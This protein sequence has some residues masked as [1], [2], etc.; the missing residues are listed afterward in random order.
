MTRP[1]PDIPRI[2]MEC[3]RN[4]TAPPYRSSLEPKRPD[5]IFDSQGPTIAVASEGAEVFV[6]SDLHLASGRG[7]DGRYDGC[8]NF[9]F[10]A[11][12]RRF[13]EYANARPGKSLL[14][15]NGDFVD[16]LRVTYVPGL[17]QKLSR[18]E[19]SLKHIHVHRRARRINALSDSDRDDFL[20]DYRDWSRILARI[21][22]EKS[23]E[24]LVNSVT[25]KEELYGLKTHDYKSVLRLHVVINGHP[26]FFDALACWLGWGHKI[27]IV[28]GNHD[29]EWYWLAV[30]NYLRLEL[31]ERLA[32]AQAPGDGEGVRHA[33]TETVLPAMLFVDHAMVI[34]GDFYVEHG[35]PYDPLTR[36]IGEDTVNEG[37]E[38]NIPFGSF[39]NRFLLNFLETDYPFLDNI[40]PT[41]NI[42]PLMLKNNFVAGIRLL[43]DHLI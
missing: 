43:I 33:L 41:Q 7:I 23:P 40:R 8:E 31:A 34:D 38:L 2:L 4:G 19:R 11:S 5:S 32:A 14:I 24:Q 27:V 12:F 25:D 22:I 29:L 28:K 30:R 20:D 36:V 10:D 16:F 3:E 18:W 6:I 39:F 21:G 15:I 35:H 42:L 26:E 1:A 17:H 37:Q 13:L 9:F